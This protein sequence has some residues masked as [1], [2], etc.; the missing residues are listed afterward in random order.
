MGT[1]NHQLHI[2]LFPFMAQGHIIPFIDMAKL[3]VSRGLKATIITTALDAPFIHKKIENSTSPVHIFT[4]EVPTLEV[5]L[6]ANCQSLHLATSPE[7]QTKFFKATGLLEPQLERFLQHKKPDCL[8]ADMF[9]PW[10]TDVAS[11]FG[12]PRLIFHGTSGFSLCTT[13]CVFL[14]KPRLQ[15]S[16]DSETF[17]IPN[18]PDEIE[19]TRKKLPDFI[20]DGVENDFSRFHDEC[21]KAE[22]RSY[23]VL[24]NS[25]YELEPA[26]ADHYT[27]VLGIKAW[28]IGPLWICNEGAKEDK[29]SIDEQHECI[30]W[31]DSKKPNSVVYV[32]FGSLSNFVDAQLLEIAKALESSGQQFIWVVKKQNNDQENQQDWLPEGFEKRIEGKGLIIRGWA[33]QVKILSHEA[34]GGFVTHCGWNSTLEAV[35]AG[36]PMATWPVFAEQFYN[37]KLITQVL[38]IGVGIGAKEWSRVAVECVKSD[39]IEKAVTRTMV[40]EEAEEMRNRARGYAEMARRAVEIGGSSHSNL[41]ALIEELRSHDIAH[42]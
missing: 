1:K 29:V 9:F 37:E 12:I 7:M 22:E 11:K 14:Y 28:H 18:L 35:C 41:N 23:G 17:F 20:R 15:V 13:L 38:R 8:V 16:S 36:V 25:F 26:Y 27:N 24:V 6:P 32:C 42:E 10:A 21:M 19:L 30:K 3:F 5:G 2:A 40:G 34:V 39:A 33:P 31:L 4:I